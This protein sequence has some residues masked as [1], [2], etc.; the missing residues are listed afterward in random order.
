MA[1][2]KRIKA[3]AKELING[4]GVATKAVGSL[5][6]AMGKAAREAQEF[7]KSMNKV[8]SVI[9]RDIRRGAVDELFEK[10]GLTIRRETKRRRSKRRADGFLDEVDPSVDT[11]AQER[12]IRDISRASGF[13][14]DEA[15]QVLKALSNIPSDQKRQNHLL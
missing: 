10:P 7:N 3:Q 8:G 2:D 13:T 11:S 6:R 14:K 9:D 15:K 1:R 5:G 12:A 4:L